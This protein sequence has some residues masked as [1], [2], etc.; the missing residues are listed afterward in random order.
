[1]TNNHKQQALKDWFENKQK[2]SFYFLLTFNQLSINHTHLSRVFPHKLKVCLP[3][4]EDNPDVEKKA[5]TRRI[6][7]R[8][9]YFAKLLDFF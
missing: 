1:M 8:F 5:I 6:T 9:H 7:L 4:S 3:V 2:C